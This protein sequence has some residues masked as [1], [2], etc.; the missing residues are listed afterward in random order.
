MK[1]KSTLYIVFALIAV[2]FFNFPIIWL[3]V[4]SLKPTDLIFLEPV[5]ITFKPTIEHFV[6]VFLQTPFLKYISNSLLVALT[7]SLLTIALSFPVGYSIARYKTGGG[8][9]LFWFLSLRISPPIVFII[10][11]YFLFKTLNLLD[12]QLGLILIYQT[13]NVPLAVWLFRSYVQEIPLDYEE[14]ALI[15]GATRLQVITKITLRLA[16]PAVIAVFVLAFIAS[17]NEFLFAL[18]LTITKS[19]TWAVG[20]Q[21]FIGT[22]D[23]QWGELSAAGIVGVIPPLILAYLLRKRLI[24]GF[25][26]GLLKG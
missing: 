11:I 6:N 22:Y 9:L 12:Q 24:E 5:S 2:G 16:L 18:I 1:K 17:W 3:A 23:I 21:I 20:S 19:R 13:F 4:V 8:S 25:T 15:D 14:A 7:S 10:P 26:M